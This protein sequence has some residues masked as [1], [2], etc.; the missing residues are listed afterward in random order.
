MRFSQPQDAVPAWWVSAL[1]LRAEAILGDGGAELDMAGGGGVGGAK[2]K[3][4][5]AAAAS[6]LLTRSRMLAME[7]WSLRRLFDQQREQVLSLEPRREKA[8]QEK[9]ELERMVMSE[10]AVQEEAIKARPVSP[11][12]LAMSLLFLLLLL[13][14]MTHTHANNP[15]Q[16]NEKCAFYLSIYLSLSLS[17]ISLSLSLSLNSSFSSHTP[18]NPKPPVAL[19]QLMAKRMHITESSLLLFARSQARSVATTLE[20]IEGATGS[21]HTPDDILLRAAQGQIAVTHGNDGRVEGADG[22][23]GAVGVEELRSVI[24]EAMSRIGA[25]WGRLERE[26]EGLEGSNNLLREKVSGSFHARSTTQRKSPRDVAALGTIITGVPVAGNGHRNTALSYINPAECRPHFCFDHGALRLWLWRSGALPRRARRLMQRKSAG[27]R[28]KRNN[29]SYNGSENGPTSSSRRLLRC[30]SLAT[31]AL[32]RCWQPASRHFSTLW[33]TL[34]G[35]PRSSAQNRGSV[36]PPDRR[37]S[38]PSE[39]ASIRHRGWGG[40]LCLSR[41]G[42]DSGLLCASSLP[43]CECVLSLRAESQEGCKS[44]HFPT[45]KSGK[46]TG[47]SHE[48]VE[49]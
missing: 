10:R 6:L 19:T 2:G 5:A 16:M 18:A 28:S 26:R 34:R 48:G 3:V 20:K 38:R 22:D 45:Q 32:I 15:K 35:V 49:H 24:G 47:K 4:G 9:S 41:G 21:E 25:L 13:H 14:S 43:L 37:T 31:H 7:V 40:D 30:P 46:T 8:E 27:A 1:C 23:G 44:A 17:L 11:F 36:R 42:A 29:G 39:I 33:G 12:A